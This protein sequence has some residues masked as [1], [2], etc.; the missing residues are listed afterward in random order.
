MPASRSWLQVLRS[1][2]LHALGLAAAAG[3]GVAYVATKKLT[4]P[5]QERY[6]EALL[7][8]YT[9]AYLARHGAH[10]PLP[11]N[12]WSLVPANEPPPGR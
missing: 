2:P 1:W 6:R 3:V 5:Q 12:P 9:D 10:V 4:P 7:K 8:I 11:A